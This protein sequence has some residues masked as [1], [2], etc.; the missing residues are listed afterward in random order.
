[1]FFPPFYDISTYAFSLVHIASIST[2]V[3]P[4]GVSECKYKI[5]NDAPC[6]FGDESF[7]ADTCS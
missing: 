5:V 1:M 7:T 4:F 6:A 3:E 2:D